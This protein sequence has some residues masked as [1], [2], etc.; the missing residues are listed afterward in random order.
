MLRGGVAI[1]IV[2]IVV[3]I[4]ADALEELVEANELLVVA[5]EVL[6][7]ISSRAVVAKQVVM[8]D[9]L[10]LCHREGSSIEQGYLI[11]EPGHGIAS[12]SPFILLGSLVGH[13]C[14]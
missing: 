8:I 6:L 4:I 5:T 10:D 11:H 2:D 3:V 14:R 13:R 1:A 7:D 9:V 12:L